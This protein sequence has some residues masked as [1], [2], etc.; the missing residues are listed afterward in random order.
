M[1]AL[2]VRTPVWVKN[3][4]FSDVYKD[5]LWISTVVEGKVQRGFTFKV[6]TDS[7]FPLAT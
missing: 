2:N 5:E 3:P 7:F 1:S 4:A 6:F